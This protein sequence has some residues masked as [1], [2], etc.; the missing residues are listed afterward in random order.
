MTSVILLS[1]VL[2]AQAPQMAGPCW[3]DRGSRSD[4]GTIEQ[5]EELQQ[6][7]RD[8]MSCTV[9]GVTWRESAIPRAS[10]FLLW[11]G[12]RE[13]LVR[14]RVEGGNVYWERWRNATRDRILL[15]DPS[16][17]IDLPVYL[18]GS[19]AA[20]VSPEARELI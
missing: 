12:G 7:F 14:V 11:D 2:G 20:A 10:S 17:G 19:G 15:E 6:A 8:E 5:V 3:I 13:E 4:D 9:W 16:D 18:R 1:L